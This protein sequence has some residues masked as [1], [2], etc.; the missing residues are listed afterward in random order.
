[1]KAYRRAWGYRSSKTHRLCEGD[2]KTWSNKVAVRLLCAVH[3]YVRGK[4]NEDAWYLQKN[5]RAAV[6][7][8][9]NMETDNEDDEHTGATTTYMI[10]YDKEWN[11]PYY[12]DEGVYVYGE[13]GTPASNRMAVA[14]LLKTD[15][16]APPLGPHM[17]SP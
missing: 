11:L 17:V 14:V 15:L 7:T 2:K 8:E 4:K 1:M 10:R 9:S 12:E 3:H 13:W 16:N 5:G 6:H